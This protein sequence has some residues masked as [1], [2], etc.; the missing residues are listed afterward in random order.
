MPAH[1]T[2]HMPDEVGSLIEKVVAYLNTCQDADV[3]KL[4]VGVNGRVSKLSF[5]VGSIKNQARWLADDGHIPK[6][7]EVDSNARESEAESE[8]E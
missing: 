3:K 6:S 1:Y 8:S 7:L 4:F 5:I 2:L